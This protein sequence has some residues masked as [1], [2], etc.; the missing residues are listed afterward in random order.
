LF[1]H[2]LKTF[3]AVSEMKKKNRSGSGSAGP[4][5]SRQHELARIEKRPDNYRP[6]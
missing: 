4:A 6:V 1:C 3:V 2:E 5:R